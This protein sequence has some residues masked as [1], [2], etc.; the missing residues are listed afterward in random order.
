MFSVSLILWALALAVV[1]LP[2]HPS[3]ASLKGSAI[4]LWI[5]AMA[6]TVIG[7]FV[8]GC[9]AGYVPGN[10]RRGIARIHGLLAWSLALVVSFVFQL[11]VLRGALAT[12]VR[13][14][15]DAAAVE[16]TGPSMGMRGGM[17]PSPVEPSGPEPSM[18]ADPAVVPPPV[19]AEIVYAGRVALDYVRGAGWS[20]FGTWFL[21]GVAA[22]GGAS[23]AVRRLGAPRESLE[24]RSERQEGPVGPTTPLT[25]APSA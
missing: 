24:G 12:A 5:C 8:G 22:L 18:R 14:L 16:S 7:A 6:A 4:A 1:S 20:W 2:A 19:R 10:P 11:A 17:S 23:F 9:V 13:A 15:A 25:P 3:A 21:A